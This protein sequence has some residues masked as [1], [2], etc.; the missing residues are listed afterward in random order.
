MTNGHKQTCLICTFLPLTDEYKNLWNKISDLLSQKNFELVLLTASE[1]FD[2]LN[3]PVIYVPFSLK[4]FYEQFRL[5]DFN[6]QNLTEND[7]HLFERDIF[8]NKDSSANF[9]KYFYGFK[10]CKQFYKNLIKELKPSIVFVWGNLLPQSLIFKD[11]LENYNIPSFYLERGYFPGSLMIEDT[12][13]KE[14]N[15]IAKQ[16]N[17]QSDKQNLDDYF[18]LKKFYDN[19]L[20]SKYPENHDFELE[21][22]ILDKKENGFNV[23]SFYGTHDTAY[24]PSEQSYSKEVSLIFKYTTEAVN[25]LSQNI[26]QLPKT[27][28]IFKPHPKDENDYS[29][30]ES[31]NFIVTKNFFNRRLFELTDAIIVGNST[32]QYEALLSDKPVILIAK[33]AVYNFNAT[34]NPKSK[35]NLLY[36]ISSAVQK[37]D[38]DERLQNSKLFFNHLIKSHIYIYSDDS[39]G[40]SLIDFVEFTIKK[41]INISTNS[42][43]SERLTAF[44]TKIFLQKQIADQKENNKFR[45]LITENLKSKF[46]DLILNHSYELDK[47]ISEYNSYLISENKTNLILQAEE[48]IE[49]NSLD[50]ARA[51]LSNAIKDPKLKL[52][53]YNDLAY[54]EIVRENYS[55]ALNNILNVLRINP[56]DEIAINNLNYLIENNFLDNSLVN[57]QLLKILRPDLKLNKVKSFDEFVRYEQTMREEYNERSEFESNLIADNSDNFTFNGYCVVCERVVPFQVDFWNAY[58]INGKKIPNWRERLVCPGCGLNNRMRLTYHLIK[59]VF[60]DF[61]SSSAYTT[62]QTT[63]LFRLLKNLNP[64]LIG[65]EYL[66]E[67]VPNGEVNSSGIRNEDFT[68]L[69]FADNQ[70]DYIISLEVLE[71]IPDYHKALRESFR[72]LKPN[73][74]FLFTVP[75]NR[76]SKENLVRAQLND[77]GTI[78]HLQPPEYHGD[79]LNRTEGCLCYYHFGWEMLNDLKTAGFADAYAI[80]T[81]SKEFGYLGGEQIFFIATKE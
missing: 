31:E 5:T 51:L 49:K 60:S 45:L 35:E 58:N 73:G 15:S 64:R 25:Y 16:C 59:E 80:F 24:F 17:I 18:R 67:K 22:Y 55:E 76:N 11:I 53:A 48:L 56:N 23:V 75:F 29:N 1:N 61:P 74:K 21:K 38:F 19:N 66:G 71:H 12:L 63:I 9:E 39:V 54:V 44:E 52:E 32:I 72:T 78:T 57:A 43:L 40:K 30:L 79:P 41:S 33:S 26:N 28:L 50:E 47:K 13:N 6:D 20:Q 77:D 42:N 70:F 68:N 81:Y 2:G 27:I 8:W 14:M 69:S 4:G 65:S 62:E 3:C 10:S 37:I 46:Y 34:Y 7:F 36:M